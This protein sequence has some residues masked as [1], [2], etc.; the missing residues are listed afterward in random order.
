M[1]WRSYYM[2]YCMTLFYTSV[3]VWDVVVTRVKFNNALYIQQMICCC[4]C[5]PLS[6][7]CQKNTKREKKGKP[8]HKYYKTAGSDVVGWVTKILY[9]SRRS[10]SNNQKHIWQGGQYH[11]S[12][13]NPSDGGRPAVFL[14]TI[15]HKII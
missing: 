12:S 7:N 5:H 1:V 8:L 4:Y 14:L 10:G 3:A 2:Y 13:T 6:K 11:Y 9:Y 15:H